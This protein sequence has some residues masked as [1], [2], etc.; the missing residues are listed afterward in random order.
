M[1]E[2][3]PHRQ[4]LS[5]LT[6]RF[7]EVGIEPRTQLGQNFLVDLNLLDVLIQAAELTPDDV[8]LEVGTGT[9]SLTAMMAGRVAAVITVEIDRRLFQ[10]ASEELM[11]MP[12]VTMLQTDA[13]AGKHGISPLVLESLERQMA[14]HPARRFKLVANL[15]YNV[16]TPL[17]MNLLG[18]ERPP[19]L[20]AVTIQKE[21]ADRIVAQPG[22]KDFGALSLWVQSQCR[23][24]LLRTLGPT[25]F[26]PRPKVSSAMVRIEYDSALR[27]RLADRHFFHEFIRAV[28][29]HRRKV[30]RSGLAAAF[31]DRLDKA[32]V[33][34]ILAEL[35]FGPNAR[36]EELDLDQMMRLA[37]AVRARGVK[38]GE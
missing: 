35:A 23:A 3:A 37:E 19:A 24:Q 21:V 7:R 9:G 25:V 26:W 17:M 32:E 15:P 10:L 2:S 31:K 14:A 29:L 20:M 16:A 18:L 6:Q 36:A 13:M 1:T 33:D 34:R 28:F 11:A 12:N 22:C 30:L 4:T 38:A 5:Y 8:V 27:A